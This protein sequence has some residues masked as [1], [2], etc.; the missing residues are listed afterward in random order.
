MVKVTVCLDE[1][2]ARISRNIY[3]HFA[4]HLGTC[5]YEGIWVGEDSIIPNT[6]GIRNDVVAALKRINPAI[7]RWPGGNFAD[8]Y[9]WQDGVGPRAARP[10]RLNL[11]WD[12]EEPN[13]F[14]THEFIQ[15]CRLVGAEPYLCGN[16]GSSYPRELRD[17]VEYC[18]YDGGTSLAQQRAANGS[19][20]PFRVRYWGVGNEN[21]AAGGS[22]EADDYAIEYKRFA[23]YLRDFGGTPLFLVA[24]GAY[25]TETS[26]TR[27][28]FEKMSR[29]PFGGVPRLHGFGVH[30]YCGTAGSATEYTEQEWYQLL[31]AGLKVE[32]VIKV[33]RAAMDSYDPQRKIGLVID[34]WGTWHPPAEG[35]NKAHLWQQNTMRDALVAALTL[36]VFNRHADKVVMANI[37]QTVNVLQAL[38]LTDGPRM[39]TTPTYHVYDLYQ[40]HQE[41]DSV[42]L[43]CDAPEI[44]FNDKQATQAKL[45]GVSGSASIKN[46]MVTISLVNTSATDA[47][48]AVVQLRGGACAGVAARLLSAAE[49]HTVNTFEEPETITPQSTTVRISGG[50]L[51]LS[52]P[53]ASV[54]VLRGRLS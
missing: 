49:M 51:H 17:W 18:N 31:S 41:G 40:G 15:F 2:I 36:D 16:V 22:F 19:S 20:E 50:E 33:H 29:T 7:L 39:L 42:R 9:H 47:Q 11:W 48:D 25:G 3:G 6:G 30:Y 13:H 4:E 27:G 45:P 10:R 26:W 35:R 14:G 43:L 1:P 32:D 38:V 8:D 53:A 23:T 5:I 46:G 34:E 44:S 52:L 12:S 37:A 54:T 21:W 28:F 24:C